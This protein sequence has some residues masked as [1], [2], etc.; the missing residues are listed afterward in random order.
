MRENERSSVNTLVI[1]QRERMA[2]PISPR[3]CT[4]VATKATCRCNASAMRSSGSASSKGRSTSWSA[5]TSASSS[6]ITKPARAASGALAPLRPA[7]RCTLYVAA[8]S[9][10]PM[11]FRGRGTLGAFTTA[12]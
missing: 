2:L 4:R 3:R 12:R 1:G 9:V 7:Q 5:I 6:E 11:R 8:L 10:R